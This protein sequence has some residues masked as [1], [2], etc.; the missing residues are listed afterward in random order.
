VCQDP[1][2]IILCGLE[3]AWIIFL[4]HKISIYMYI[5]KWEKEKEKGK[6]F[7]ALVGRGGGEFRPSMAQ[8]RET[9]SW[10][11]AHALGRAGGET[12]SA[13]MGKGGEPAV[14]R[15]KP[16]RRRVQR[17]F[18]TGDPVL[19]ERVGA[20][21]REEAGELKGGSNFARCD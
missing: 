19:G 7:S 14:P 8:G 4:A 5:T 20:I 12:T 3:S 2:I 9:A 17:R 15:G 18:S 11:R 1:N 21:A 13:Q 10:L 16:G 6:G